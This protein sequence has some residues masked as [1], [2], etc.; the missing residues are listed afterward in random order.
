MG[1]TINFQDLFR[2]GFQGLQNM[3][4]SISLLDVAIALFIGLITGLFI[5]FIYRKAFR[6]VVYNHNFNVTL[7][8][9]TMITSLIILTISTNIVLSLGMVGALSI[10]R[11]RT[12]IKDPLDIVFMFWSI[13]AGIAIGAKVYSVALLGSLILG[14]TVYFLAKHKLKGMAYLLIIH[15]KEEA[16]YAVNYHLKGLGH[17]L[18]SKTIRNQTIEL[19]VELKLKEEKTEFVQELSVVEGVQ[20]VS[21]V[22][23]NGD[24]AP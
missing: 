1:D 24:Y 4:S 10:V 8:L 15:F 16:E 2:Q 17:K 18:K 7:V 20:D 14:V 22:S 19:V 6:G 21:L 9:M 3:M 13:S 5:F 12:A 23:Y 11:F